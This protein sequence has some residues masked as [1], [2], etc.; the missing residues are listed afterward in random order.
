MFLSTNTCEGKRECIHKCPTKAIKLINGRA[1][2]CLTCGICYKNCPNGAIFQNSYGGYVV[3]RAKCNGCGMCMHNCPTNNITIEDGIVYGICSR[4]GVCEEICPNRVDG[5]ELEK[6]KQ[7]TLIESMNILNPPLK[8]VPHR[9]EYLVT[10]VSRGYFGTDTEKCI[11]CGRCGEYC[12]TGAIHVKIDRDE[13]ICSEC[14][15]CVDV[16]PN[17]SMNKYQMAD[18]STCTL[19]LNCMK[20]CPNNAISVDDFKIVVNKIKQ[21][22]TGSI[23]SCLNCGLCADLCENESLKNVDGKLRYDPTADT[24]NI[25]HAGA[26]EACPIHTL[27][28]DEEMFIYDEFDD[29]EL[30]TLSG[31]CVSCGK[32]VQVCDEVGARQ[33]M[34]YTWDGTVSDDCISCGICSEVCQ[35]G[36][37]TLH[38]GSISV[39]LDK[40]ILCENCAVHCPV[41]AIPRTTLFKYEVE[42]GFNFIE[43]KLCMH[44]GLC[45][46]ICSYD[47]IDEID[48]NFVVNEEKCTYCGACKNACPA[49]AFLFERNF[50]DSIE[51]I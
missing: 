15:L 46:N 10:E 36:A 7:I 19:C 22:P 28:E 42:D 43:Q 4:C 40:C 25:T 16:C 48:G 23:V 20:A 5:F 32:C 13:G 39:A 37:I 6:E 47:A 44:C 49:R 31:F 12:P 30:P 2:S 24:E 35:E 34:T 8:D 27:R 41:D 11:L 17:G 18:K 3:D 1:F 33:Y 38:K 14:R 21:K 51:G 45:H 50:K 9:P 29:E 26:I